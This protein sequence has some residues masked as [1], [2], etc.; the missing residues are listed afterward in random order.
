MTSPDSTIRFTVS[1]PKT[2]LD[3]LDQRVVNRGYASRSELVRDLI[4]ER[5]VEETWERGD[6][7][8]AGVLTI[9]Y[10]HHQRELTR[11][12]LDIQHH[13][14]VHVIATTHVHLDHHNCLETIILRGM[15]AEIERLSLEIGGLRGVRFAELTRTSKVEH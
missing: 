5:I 13:Q 2:L 9:V 7:E 3:E 8:V 11:Q 14:Y 1:L 15:P 12:I 10:D 6:A 4:R